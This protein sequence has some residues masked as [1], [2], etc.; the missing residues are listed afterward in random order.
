VPDIW[1][2]HRH[3][4]PHPFLRSSISLDRNSLKF[5]NLSSISAASLGVKVSAPVAARIV[6]CVSHR[7]ASGRFSLIGEKQMADLM[8]NDVPDTDERG[9]DSAG[10]F[11]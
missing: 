7:R 1:V 6:C 2:T 10:T 9:K 5:C 3:L 11:H 8:R 4:R